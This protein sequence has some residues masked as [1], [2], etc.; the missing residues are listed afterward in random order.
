MSDVRC[1]LLSNG[2]PGTSS[3]ALILIFILQSM[4]LPKHSL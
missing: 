4:L 2:K 1:P 3:R